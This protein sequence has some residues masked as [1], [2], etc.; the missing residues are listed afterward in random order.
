MARRMSESAAWAWLAKKW[1]NA[2]GHSLANDRTTVFA[3]IKGRAHDGI[4]GCLDDL[5]LDGLIT[6]DVQEKMRLAIKNRVPTKDAA[7]LY[8]WKLNSAGSKQRAAFCRKMAA[9]TKVKR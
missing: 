4:C 3:W 7:F 1:D 8:K 5:A 9:K 6:I 2:S